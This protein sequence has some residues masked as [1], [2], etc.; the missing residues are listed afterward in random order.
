MFDVLEVGGGDL[1]DRPY[2]ERRA[3]LEDLF[4]RDV[5]GAPFTLCPVT[6]DRA[7]A[8]E[9]LDPAWGEVGLC[10][11]FELARELV[12][13]NDRVRTANQQG[14]GEGHPVCFADIVT[15]WHVDLKRRPRAGRVSVALQE[16]DHARLGL[17]SDVFQLLESADQ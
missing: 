7:T 1:L 16:G 17:D 6:T 8:L 2:R 10:A 14:R 4:A 13:A 11:W 15:A 9:W 5:L 3:M 12:V